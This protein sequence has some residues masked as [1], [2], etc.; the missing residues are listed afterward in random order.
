MEA[1]FSLPLDPQSYDKSINPRFCIAGIFF[2]SRRCFSIAEK[3]HG[4]VLKIRCLNLFGF[5][6]EKIGALQCDF[7]YLM[8]INKKIYC[9]VYGI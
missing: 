9:L 4:Y 8:E 1:L 2:R 3:Y 5:C 7:N 6:S